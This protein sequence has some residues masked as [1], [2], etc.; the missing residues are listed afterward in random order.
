MVCSGGWWNVLSPDRSALA[1]LCC[2][3]RAGWRSL[4][5]L[6]LLLLLLL[7][8][9]HTP[10]RCCSYCQTPPWGEFT[11]PRRGSLW[12]RRG[13][14]SQCGPPRS[15]GIRLLQKCRRKGEG[16]SHSHRRAGHPLSSIPLDFQSHQEANQRYSVQRSTTSR[17][18]SGS[19]FVYPSSCLLVRCLSVSTPPPSDGLRL[20][21]A[22]QQGKK[23]AREAE[24]H[25]VRLIVRCRFVVSS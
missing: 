17:T 9:V 14:G 16:A 1:P 23:T 4:A 2:T 8:Y 13:A 7:L 3:P 20:T 21:D 18:S 15:G 25:R 11:P 12:A 24:D 5:L 6:L 22:M 19:H 10:C